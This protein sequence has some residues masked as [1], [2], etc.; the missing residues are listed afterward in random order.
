MVPMKP[1]LNQVPCSRGRADPAAVVRVTCWWFRS[2]PL[3]GSVP[4]REPVPAPEVSVNQL[5][6]TA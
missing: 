6:F 5:L 1:S 2:A 4:A 3:A